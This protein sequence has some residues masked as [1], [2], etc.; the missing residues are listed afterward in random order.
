MKTFL[1]ISLLVNLFVISISG[2]CD[3]KFS[4]KVWD[5]N[6]SMAYTTLYSLT[7]NT[8]VVKYINGLKNGKDSFLLKRGLS[9]DDCK[10]ISD[11]FSSH[12]ISRLNS[13][14][15]NN[16]VDDG[17]QKKVMIEVDGKVKKIEISNFYQKDLGELFDAIN[18]L[19]GKTI[20]IKYK[21]NR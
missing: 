5:Y 3:K 18:K 14:Y 10:I 9:E 6:Y 16:M 12:D 1:L 20:R 21:V 13:S 4:I 11:F 7:N 2:D 8:I 15:S 17:D 19:V